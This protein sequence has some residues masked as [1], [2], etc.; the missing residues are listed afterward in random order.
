MEHQVGFEP[1]NNSF[2]DYRDILYA[3]GALVRVRGLEPPE[4]SVLGC[5]LCHSGT[6][7]YVTLGLPTYRLMFIRNYIRCPRELV[8]PQGFKPWVNRL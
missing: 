5:S 3:I 7:A 2:A 8:E 1:T 4:H 6:P